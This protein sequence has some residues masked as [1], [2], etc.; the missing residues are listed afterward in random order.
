MQV[1]VT[2][3]GPS[4]PP[5]PAWLPDQ[6]VTLARMLAAYTIEGAR[7]AFQE[8]ETGSIVVGKA[9]DLV[10]LDRNLLTLPAHQIARAWVR[11]TFFEGREVYAANR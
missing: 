10:V 6:R 7:L 8:R 3:R 2:R 9:A 1:A 11:Y 5:G 4:A